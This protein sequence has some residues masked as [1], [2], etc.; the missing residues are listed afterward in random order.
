MRLRFWFNLWIMSFFSK[1]PWHFINAGEFARKNN[2]KAAVESEKCSKE[3]F[4][5][6]KRKDERE[7]FVHSYR[8]VQI[9]IYHIFKA[10]PLQHRIFES[11]FLDKLLTAEY[12][13][14]V[15]EDISLNTIEDI[16]RSFGNVV[17]IWTWRLTR[18]PEETNRDYFFG[19]SA[20]V[21]VVIAKIADRLHN[22][23][24]MTNNLGK[25][26]FFTDERLSNQVDET[27]NEVIPMIRRALKCKSM[28]NP[29]I[30]NMLE[31]LLAALVAADRALIR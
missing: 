19:A 11:R 25:N 4:M 30:W 13:H 14:D 12:F 9:T 21:A 8:V 22:L 28:F 16:R 18:K 6:M 26:D 3:Y 29:M 15:P 1:T 20:F 23:R 10:F 17:G 2:L 24:N 31:E 27:W 5:S 7:G